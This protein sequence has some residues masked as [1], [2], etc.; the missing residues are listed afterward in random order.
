MLLEGVAQGAL[1]RRERERHA[2]AG[3][4]DRLCLRDDHVVEDR[5]SAFDL[6]EQRVL[7]VR[8]GPA[9]AGCNGSSATGS[10]CAAVDGRT[11]ALQARPVERV[12]AAAAAARQ[13]EDAT[14][15][16]GAAAR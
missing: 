8:R 4:L 9:G 16:A 5:L 12:A 11:S 1:V 13:S 15:A 2:I 6:R 7:E 3:D 10:G 14:R